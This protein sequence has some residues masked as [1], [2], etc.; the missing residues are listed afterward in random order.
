MGNQHFEDVIHWPSK[1]FFSC[2]RDFLRKTTL[3]MSLILTSR[4]IDS[5]Y[6]LSLFCLPLHDMCEMQLLLLVHQVSNVFCYCCL[7]SPGFQWDVGD[8][9][10]PATTGQ[11]WRLNQP[12]QVLLSSFS[13]VIPPSACVV[14]HIWPSLKCDLSVITYSST[15]VG[16]CFGV[17]VH[18]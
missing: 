9:S 15:E 6:S 5:F 8:V 1:C 10:L 11:C 14:G 3:S 13:Q 2:Q 4:I 18:M 16:R 17:W 7:F 12:R